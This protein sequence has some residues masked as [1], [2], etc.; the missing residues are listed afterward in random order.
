MPKAKNL[1]PCIISDCKN[2]VKFNKMTSYTIEK[3]S[4]KDSEKRYG[5]IKEGDQLCYT[6]Y[7]EIVEPDRHDQQKKRKSA[8]EVD[9][10]KNVRAKTC[11]EPLS[12]ESIDKL[13]WSKIKLN[14][15]EEN[16]VISKEDFSSL[17]NN[18]NQMKLQLDNI[19][20]HIDEHEDSSVD[21]TDKDV[22]DEGNSFFFN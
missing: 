5:F 13:D 14:F 8:L 11:D 10:S 18:I 6:H 2:T 16:V 12:S 22:D 20:C 17:V 21:V 19:L 15:T 1:G 7:L 3:I 9:C 4:D